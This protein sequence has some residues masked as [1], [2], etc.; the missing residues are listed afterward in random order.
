MDRES[1]S[2]SFDD[3]SRLPRGV[4][5]SLLCAQDEDKT[6]R[7]DACL[8]DS[9][10]PL[11]MSQGPNYSIVG[12]TAFGQACGN[13]TPGVYTAVYSYL[14]WIEKQVWPEISNETR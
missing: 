10:G 4:D 7:A 11:L 12:V 5:E 9:G 13:P 1:C 3:F 14:D 6:R 8:G 2:K